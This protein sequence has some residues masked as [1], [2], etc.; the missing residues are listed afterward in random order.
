M[1]NEFSAFFLQAPPLSDLSSLGY[2]FD[3]IGA[4]SPCFTLVLR[5]AIRN[6]EM[7]T[8]KIRVKY[9]KTKEIWRKLYK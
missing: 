4:D 5:I 1:I 9:M 3:T 7:K 8:V 2:P 6:I